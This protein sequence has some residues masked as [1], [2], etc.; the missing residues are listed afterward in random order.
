MS[1]L[2]VF[3]HEG[4]LVIDSRLVA[5]EMGMKHDLLMETINRYKCV[6]SQELG[7]FRGDTQKLSGSGRGCPPN[8]YYF[9]EKQASFFVTMLSENSEPCR[10]NLLKAFSQ[11]KETW[12]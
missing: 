10:I 9:N 5:Q 12:K 6:W 4:E 7:R 1:D 8:F 11:A 2:V 3:E